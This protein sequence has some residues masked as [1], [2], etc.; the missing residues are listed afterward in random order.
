VH[1]KLEYISMSLYFRL[2]FKPFAK[3]LFVFIVFIWIFNTF[4]IDVCTYVF[5]VFL[6]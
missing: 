3:L 1:I 4:N 6:F 5:M 2:E